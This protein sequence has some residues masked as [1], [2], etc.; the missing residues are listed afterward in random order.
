[1]IS[2]GVELP[3]PRVLLASERAAAR[4]SAPTPEVSI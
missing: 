2:P 4:R 3:P 1:M